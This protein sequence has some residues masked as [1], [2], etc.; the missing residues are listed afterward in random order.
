[1]NN[2]DQDPFAKYDK[3]FED[4]DK[5]LIVKPSTE[6][7]APSHDNLKDRQQHGDSKNQKNVQ[8]IRVILIV[9]FV[10][11][12]IQVIPVVLFRGGGNFTFLPVFSFIFIIV[13]I[14]I[15]IKAFK[16]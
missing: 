12:A 10:V 16:R 15:L 2:H 14:N 7:K 4:A 3:L 13:V 1:M 11:F 5:N 8:A 9:F 6:K